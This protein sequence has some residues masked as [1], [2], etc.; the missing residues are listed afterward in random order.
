M[1]K[2]LVVWS[3]PELRHGSSF[4]RARYRSFPIA[5]SPDHLLRIGTKQGSFQK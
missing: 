4:D 5:A 3:R 1:T 2:T